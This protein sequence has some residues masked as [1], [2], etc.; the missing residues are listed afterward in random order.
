MYVCTYV[1]IYTYMCIYVYAHKYVHIDFILVFY[2]SFSTNIQTHTH[3]PLDASLTDSVPENRFQEFLVSSGG[4][5]GVPEKIVLIPS[6]KRVF[7]LRRLLP[8]GA[9]TH[10]VKK[11]CGFPAAQ[12][13]SHFPSIRLYL[14]VTISSVG[15]S[16][17]PVPAPVLKALLCSF[18]ALA[19]CCR[20]FTWEIAKGRGSRG[21]RDRGACTN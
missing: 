16:V 18:P 15:L 9:R 14:H 1:C 5:K 3:L 6:K 8:L 20:L 13:S 2:T 11:N 17:P 10:I 12:L 7:A 4:G 19:A 21:E